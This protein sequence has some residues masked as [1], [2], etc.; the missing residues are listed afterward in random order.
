[1]STD[2]PA[3][4]WDDR[5]PYAPQPSGPQPYA[6]PYGQQPAGQPSQQPYAHASQP[7]APGYGHP[8]HGQ[9][10]GQGYGQGGYG[11]G[12]YGQ[13]YAQPYAQ[14][15]GQPSYGQPYGY[16]SPDLAHWGLRVLALTIDSLISG[17]PLMVAYVFAFATAEPSPG[18]AEPQ[19]TAAGGFAL[20]VGFV[21]YLTTWVLSRLV[22]QG[23]TGQSW[24]KRA[25]GIRLVGQHTGLPVGAGRSFVRELAHNLDGILY[26]GY[27]MPLWDAQRQTFADKVMTTIVVKA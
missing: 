17:V 23:R 9:A 7:S 5:N 3:P 1:M 15:Y 20:L 14:G 25:V 4:Q 16:A 12:G 2:Q 13:P 26:I 21:V 10:Y 18:Y 6:Q 8:G 11:Q 27:L 22:A 24:G 19:P